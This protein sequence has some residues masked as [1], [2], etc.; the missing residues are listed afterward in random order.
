MFVR[1]LQFSLKY[2]RRQ[3]MLRH[4]TDMWAVNCISLL[5]PILVTSYLAL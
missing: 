4:M 2:F 5:Y 1:L 3:W